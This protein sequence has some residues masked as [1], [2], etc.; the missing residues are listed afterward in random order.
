M[1]QASQRRA[2]ANNRR[3]LADRGMARY[4]VRG[5]ETDKKLV[6]MLA[7]RL[8][9]DDAEAARLRA[10]VEKQVAEPSC[11]GGVWA[12]LRRSPWVGASLNLER[13]TVP[14]RDVDL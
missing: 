11:R 13:E 7:K 12:A 8:A 5:L 10:E 14:P 3:R 6:R 2:V 4:E 1:T 9:R